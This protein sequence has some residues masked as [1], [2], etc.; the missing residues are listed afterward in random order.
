M[1]NNTL[2]YV[3]NHNAWGQ[4]VKREL[5]AQ[6]Y[7]V[8]RGY[9]DPSRNDSFASNGWTEKRVSRKSQNLIR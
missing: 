4:R 6:Q 2:S 3:D 7:F 5:G 8:S 1:Y 9:N